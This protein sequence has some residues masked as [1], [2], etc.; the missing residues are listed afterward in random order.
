MHTVEKIVDNRLLLLVLFCLP[1]YGYNLQCGINNIF[2]Q[3]VFVHAMYL[4]GSRKVLVV[5]LSY[6]ICFF[7]N[8]EQVHTDSNQSMFYLG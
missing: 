1:F 4:R 2:I 8:F 3:C 6:I 7:L 5:Q